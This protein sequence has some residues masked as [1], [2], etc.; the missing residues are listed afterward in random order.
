VSARYVRL[1]VT[2]S[3]YNGGSVY[4]LQVYGGS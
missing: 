3:S 4:E 1:T 2:G